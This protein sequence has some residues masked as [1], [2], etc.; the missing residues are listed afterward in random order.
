MWL[1]TSI[2]LKNAI[3]R[4]FHVSMQNFQ[5]SL[6]LSR[7]MEMSF[8][9]FLRTVVFAILVLGRWLNAFGAT[10]SHCAGRD[11]PYNANLPTLSSPA[12]GHFCPLYPPP[13]LPFCGHQSQALRLRKN[14]FTKILLEQVF[15]SLYW[16]LARCDDYPSRK[17]ETHIAAM[18]CKYGNYND[19]D[20]DVD[21]RDMSHHY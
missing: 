16:P 9:I 13:L 19:I 4:S 5:I 2:W 1:S 20:T 6:R 21:T 11:T 8:L 15:Q 3:D 10:L 12:C 7:S 18:H 17:T 14:K